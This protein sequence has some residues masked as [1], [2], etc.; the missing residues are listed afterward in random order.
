[1]NS[2]LIGVYCFIVTVQ[3]MSLWSYLKGRHSKPICQDHQIPLYLH[4]AFAL[5]H[6]H[7]PGNVLMSKELFLLF[8]FLHGIRNQTCFNEPGRIL[9]VYQNLLSYSS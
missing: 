3:I 8:L 1:M 6:L 2:Y 7:D 9:S 5:L 4:R